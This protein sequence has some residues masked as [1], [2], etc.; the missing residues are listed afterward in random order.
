MGVKGGCGCH[1]LGM[2]VGKGRKRREGGE[3]AGDWWV[4]AGRDG[5]RRREGG[6]REE[7]DQMMNECGWRCRLQV[8]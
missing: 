6:R 4:V 1:L 5:R 8:N 7:R 3:G 2:E